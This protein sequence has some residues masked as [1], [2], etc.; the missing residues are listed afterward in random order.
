[1]T[2]KSI[3]FHPLTRGDKI[4]VCSPSGPIREQKKFF[5]GIEILKSIGLIPIWQD[6]LFTKTEYLAGNIQR[7]LEEILYCFQEPGIAAIMPARGGFG[8]MHLLLH[9]LETREEL[10]PRPLIGCSDITALHSFNVEIMGH[11]SFHGPTVCQLAL[12][13]EK[14]LQAFESLLFEG[15]FP[16]EDHQLQMVLPGQAQG[17][18]KGGNL[19]IIASLIG[20]PFD[21]FAKDC[22]LLLED[23]NEPLY[24]ID[25]MLSHFQLTGHLD[26]IKG[27]ILGEF[28]GCQGEGNLDEIFSRYFSPLKIPIIKGLKSGHGDL[29]YL[30]PLG[31]KVSIKTEPC[32]IVII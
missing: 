5:Q 4:A 19:S 27:L 3:P 21:P 16:W 12:Q 28:I 23:V 22:I 17:R 2:I 30:L 10:Q 6:D 8:S 32:Q 15:V 29:N 24:K 7:R 25:R 14:S 11:Y 9:L 20:T 1:M 13:Q 31:A 26:R 18:L